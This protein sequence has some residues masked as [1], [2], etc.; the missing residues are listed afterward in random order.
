MTE[1]VAGMGRWAPEL[2]LIS[3]CFVERQYPTELD[4]CSTGRSTV[5]GRRKHIKVGG[6]S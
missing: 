1:I 4:L 5:K 6:K 2:L 3:L